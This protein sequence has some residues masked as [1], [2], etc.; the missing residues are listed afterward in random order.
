M[1]P[2]SAPI[3]KGKQAR[4]FVKQIEKPLTPEQLKIFQEA[5]RVFQA[6]KP[7]TAKLDKT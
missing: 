7:R 4:E 6:I 1:R 3:L 5:D 2:E